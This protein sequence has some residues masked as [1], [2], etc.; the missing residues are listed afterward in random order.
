MWWVLGCLCFG[1]GF[2]VLGLGLG[3]GLGDLWVWLTHDIKFSSY[4]ICC[5]VGF[6]VWGVC[7]LFVWVLGLLFG[8]FGFWVGFGVLGFGFIV[9]CVWF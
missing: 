2:G 7:A 5:L 1:F 9:C 6:V 3:L 8:G 4:Y